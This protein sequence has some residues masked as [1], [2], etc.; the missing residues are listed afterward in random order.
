MI[1]SPLFRSSIFCQHKLKWVSGRRSI[2]VPSRARDICSTTHYLQSSI[3]S[4]QLLQLH[5]SKRVL[6]QA[7]YSSTAQSVHTESDF[8]FPWHTD[9]ILFIFPMIPNEIKGPINKRTIRKSHYFKHIQHLP[10]GE[11]H[12]ALRIPSPQNCKEGGRIREHEIWRVLVRQF[13]LGMLFT[14][15]IPSSA[16]QWDA[17]NLKTGQ[18]PRHP[19]RRW[20]PLKHVWVCELERATG[21]LQALFQVVKYPKAKWDHLYRIRSQGSAL[22]TNNL[23]LSLHAPFFRPSSQADIRSY[24]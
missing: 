21:G 17:V 10:S 1:I 9:G 6:S 7:F 11:K 16:P 20:T 12:F 19:P 2:S 15:L 13:A 14:A 5:W 23:T 8:L 24:A 18:Y 22:P 3:K 4:T